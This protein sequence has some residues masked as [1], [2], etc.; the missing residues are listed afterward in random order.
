MPET[1]RAAL[2]ALAFT[3]LRKAMSIGEER[4]QELFVP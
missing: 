1:I 3:P 4:Q 2:D